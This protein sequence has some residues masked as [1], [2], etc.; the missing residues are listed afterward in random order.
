MFGADAQERY[1]RLVLE[2]GRGACG[3]SRAT[4]SGGNLGPDGARRL[5]DLLLKAPLPLL[6]SLDLRHV[7]KLAAHTHLAAR[8]RTH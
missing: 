7:I 8:R 4:L 5:A 6:V 2:S 1:C 3:T